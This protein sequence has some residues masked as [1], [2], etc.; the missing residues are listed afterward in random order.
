MQQKRG[1]RDPAQRQR[2]RERE[3]W[4]DGKKKGRIGRGGDKE[5]GGRSVKD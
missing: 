3:G 1:R 5:T 4:L 2:Q